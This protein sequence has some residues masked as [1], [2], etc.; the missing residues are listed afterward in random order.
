MHLMQ[1]EINHL[2][3]EVVEI[4]KN[5]VNDRDLLKELTEFDRKVS[6]EVTHTV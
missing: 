2:K 6:K 5:D 3:D 1:T 4:K